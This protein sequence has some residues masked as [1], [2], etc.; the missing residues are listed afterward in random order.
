MFP[1]V[2][3]FLQLPLI[4][5]NKALVLSFYHFSYIFLSFSFFL[6]I[7]CQRKHCFYF[8]FPPQVQRPYPTLGGEG[9]GGIFQD[10]DPWVSGFSL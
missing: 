2:C 9:G 5:C 7:S 3:I 10:K 8:I 6:S 4:L 1:I